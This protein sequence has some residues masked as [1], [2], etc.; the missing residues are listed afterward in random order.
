ML[1]PKI[2]RAALLALG[3]AV[4]GVAPGCVLAAE[5]PVV[6]EGYEPVYYDG[7]VVYYDGAGVPYYYIDGDIRYVPRTYVQYDILVHHYRTYRPAY[8][9]WY[10]HGGYR[11][12]RYHDVHRAPAAHPHRHPA[13]PHHHQSTP[14][15]PHHRR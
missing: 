11:Y 6:E 12:K 8:H 3:L 4:A 14:H 7:Y 10:V 5:A 9:R 2:S 13:T 1:L 15:P